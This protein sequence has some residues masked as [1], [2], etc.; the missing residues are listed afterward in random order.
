M[1]SVG[2]GKLIEAITPYR[3]GVRLLAKAAVLKT[4]TVSAVRGFGSHSL[5]YTYLQADV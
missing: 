3:G 4:V 1:T 5:R 2:L